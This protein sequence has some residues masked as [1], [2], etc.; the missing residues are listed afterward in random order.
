MKKIKVAVCGCGKMGQIIVRYLVESGVDLIAVFDH[1]T[2]VGLNV[3]TVCGIT[4]TDIFISDVVN[5]ESV[6]RENKPDICIV[7]TK[8][9]LKDV[10]DIFY[11]CANLGVNVTSIC[12]EAFF[13]QNSSP[14]LTKTLDEIAKRNKCTL[15]GTGYQDVAW[16]YLISTIAGSLFKISKIKG[17]SS[18]NVED[19]GMALAKAHG[20]GFS[21]KQFCEELSSRI[22]KEEQDL[23]I[24]NGEFK[25]SYRWNTNGWLASK[26]GLKITSQMQFNNPIISQFHIYSDTLGTTI[27]ASDVIGMSSVVN[28]KTQEGIEIEFEC[29]GKIYTDN[30]QDEYS[31]SIYGENLEE[32]ITITIPEPKTVERTCATVIN[33]IP[34]I[35]NAPSGFVTTDQMA[36]PLYR[37]KPLSEYIK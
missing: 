22:S 5:L 28:T 18:Y 7:A 6:L 25:P 8:S 14:K 12:E 1:N 26:L 10:Y 13:P 9:L 19:Y 36:A 31:F 32:L 17:R 37:A 23:L 3:G 15:C 35:I 2:K 29:I 21:I 11:T 33:R 16:G 4:E 20:V 24:E 30:D 34:D 27:K